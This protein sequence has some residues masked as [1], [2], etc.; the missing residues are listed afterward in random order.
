MT[1]TKTL[2]LQE[3]RLRLAQ[4]YAQTI[5]KCD[6]AIAAG[7]DDDGF[8]KEVRAKIIPLYADTVAAIVETSIDIAIEFS[9]SGLTEQTLLEEM[10]QV[11]ADYKRANK[12]TY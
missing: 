1:Y 2:E 9:R 4:S 6:E 11:N 5:L 7:D 3:M 10:N 12:I 8:F